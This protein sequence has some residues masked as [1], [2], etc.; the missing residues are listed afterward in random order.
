MEENQP[1]KPLHKLS[2]QP[3]CG[4]L[5]EKVTIFE[6]SFNK[7]YNGL[8]SLEL[9]MLYSL[10]YVIC[11]NP[12]HNLGR[13]KERSKLPLLHTLKR[14]EEGKLFLTFSCFGFLKWKGVFLMLFGLGLC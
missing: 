3:S 2:S 14:K 13:G 8:N 11:E 1:H 5:L 9:A 7:C 10:C 6:D 12:S 4:K